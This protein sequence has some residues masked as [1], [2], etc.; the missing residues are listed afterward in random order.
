VTRNNRSQQ[1]IDPDTRLKRDVEKKAWVEAVYR[2]HCQR[3]FRTCLRFSGNDRQWAHDRT[4]EVFAKLLEKIDVVREREDPGGWL[5]RVAVNTCFLAL[6]RGRIT[7]RVLAAL[8]LETKTAA[9]AASGKERMTTAVENAIAGLPAEERAVM[10]LL[11]LDNH[12]QAQAAELL[13]M[14]Q[15]QVS[16]LR[17]RAVKAL[18]QQEWDVSDA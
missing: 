15:G 1:S 14:S 17:A 12:T 18:R 4:H 11:H 10:T 16:K 7:T 8:H 5:Y 3:V 2:Q 9:P 13:G 6:R